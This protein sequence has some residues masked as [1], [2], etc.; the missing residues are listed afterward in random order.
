MS[1]SER[2]LLIYQIIMADDS[3]NILNDSKNYV[4]N[5][6]SSNKQWVRL[7]VGGT[8]FLTTKTTLARDQ[9]SFL[10]RLCQ[11]DSDLISDRVSHQQNRFYESSRFLCMLTVVNGL[12]RASKFS[13]VA[14]GCISKEKK[15]DFTL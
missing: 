3:D 2:S 9:S 15:S 14:S 8:I 12:G 13:E 5:S 7:N 1:I 10:Y 4:N 11:E 6:K